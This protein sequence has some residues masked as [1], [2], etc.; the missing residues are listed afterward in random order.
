MSSSLLKGTKFPSLVIK[1]SPYLGALYNSSKA[2][3][4]QLHSSEEGNLV[5]KI[6]E[7]AG[8]SLMKPDLQQSA[9]QNQATN[10]QR[11]APKTYQDNTDNERTTFVQDQFPYGRQM[12][13]N[14]RRRG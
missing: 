2:Q 13:N 5:N 4:F 7:L 14:I 1:Y 12:N 3:D 8:I 6:L 9:L 10:A 11:P